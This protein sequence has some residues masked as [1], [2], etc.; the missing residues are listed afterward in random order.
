MANAS[1]ELCGPCFK[2]SQPICKRF[3]E[4]I[5]SA[6]GARFFWQIV[7]ENNL[8][9]NRRCRVDIPWSF[10]EDHGSE[11]PDNIVKL[12]GKEG[13]E[14]HRAKIGGNRRVG[15]WLEWRDFAQTLD[16]GIGQVIVFT[17]VETCEF[18]VQIYK[19]GNPSSIATNGQVQTAVPPLVTPKVEGDD[20]V[21]I[22]EAQDWLAAKV[23]KN[24]IN[25]VIFPLKV[26]VEKVF[27]E[28][29]SAQ[30]IQAP[31]VNVNGRQK[32]GIVPNDLEGMDVSDGIVEASDSSRWKKKFDSESFHEGH[33]LRGTTQRALRYK[34]SELKTPTE[35]QRGLEDLTSPQASTH[36]SSSDSEENGN[37][38]TSSPSTSDSA[39]SPGKSHSHRGGKKSAANFAAYSDS[40]TEDED[41]D[42]E[43]GEDGVE[44]NQ[45][46]NKIAGVKRSSIDGSSSLA[47][48][49]R[50]RGRPSTRI[51]PQ[52]GLASADV[53]MNETR[54]GL[55]VENIVK[56]H[57]HDWH[58]AGTKRGR[59]YV[60]KRRPVTESE[61]VKTLER[62]KKVQLKYPSFSKRLHKDSCYR[63]VIMFPPTQF[64]RDH[65]ISGSKGL[66]KATLIDEEGKSWPTNIRGMRIFWKH[67]TLDHYLEEDDVV[68]FELVDPRLESFTFLVHIFRVVDVKV[69]LTGK[70]GWAVHY[71][72]VEGT[73]KQYVE[74]RKRML[75]A[76]GLKKLRKQKQKQKQKRKDGSSNPKI[77]TKVTKFPGDK[78][79]QPPVITE[80]YKRASTS[81]GKNRELQNVKHASDS[82]IADRLE[83]QR[84]FPW[85]RPTTRARSGEMNQSYGELNNTS[86]RK[87][88][89]SVKQEMEDAP[90][91]ETPGTFMENA[92]KSVNT[93]PSYLELTFGKEDSN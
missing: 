18:L 78:K 83:D 89:G 43:D 7:E 91:L 92:V 9:T 77:N 80:V 71:N 22:G 93:E 63:S 33:S 48:I 46:L 24:A 2:G 88:V 25:P 14:K 11:L 17:L 47:E 21:E 56:R 41:E 86:P 60:S 23:A 15:Y 49:K 27:S 50:K 55:L 82:P 44:D 42:D 19:L 73:K 40:D 70:A 69:T 64:Y 26:K 8:P 58:E 51:K 65:M 59:T 54:A 45:V 62:A 67:F 6:Y 16:I 36:E 85:K 39:W 75:Q 37:S 57:G 90:P 10:M 35:D 72:V 61:K 87:S 20:D 53:E 76:Q 5:I 52:T 31:N 12:Q 84:R 81:Q 74:E 13:S 79:K 3:C 68:I 1:T 30:G 28:T 34:H 29:S 38:D 4:P 32:G 66:Y